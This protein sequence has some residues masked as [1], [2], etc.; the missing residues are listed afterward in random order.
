MQVSELDSGRAIGRHAGSSMI[1]SF[2]RPTT[3]ISSGPEPN[4]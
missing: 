2:G 3:D 4:D 1:P